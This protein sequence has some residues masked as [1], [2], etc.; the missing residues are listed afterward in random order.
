ME[1][2][3]IPTFEGRYCID[4]SGNIYSYPK[5]QNGYKFIRL[6]KNIYPSG[7]EGLSLGTKKTYLVHRLVAITFLE[8]KENKACVNHKNGIKHDNR[9]ENLEWC[10][11][12]ENELHSYRVL[13]KKPIPNN[14][15]KFGLLSTSSKQVKGTSLLDGTVIYF[16]SA[17]LS[18]DFG[19]V[20]SK[21]SATARGENKYHKN[22]LW[23][24]ITKEEYIKNMGYDVISTMVEV[25]S[26]KKV[27]S[28]RLKR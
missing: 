3:D 22:Y 21:V 7:Y 18:S 14:K 9:V 11:Y 17:S 13:K 20:P 12:S 19:F 2:K 23:E 16:Q 1:L 6:R 4:K 28:Y 8:N 5:K 26:G 25:N 10:T 24:Y 27:A 15:N